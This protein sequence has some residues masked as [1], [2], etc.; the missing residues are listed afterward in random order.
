M[1]ASPTP[2]YIVEYDNDQFPGYV[3]EEEQPMG[4]RVV[5]QNILNRHGGIASPAGAEMMQISLNF[6]VLSQ[7]DNVSDLL[8][9]NNCKEQYIEAR[10]IVARASGMADLYISDMTKHVRAFPTG[11]TAPLVAGTSRSIHYKV[12]F[13]ADPFYIGDTAV[14]DSFTGND[15]LSL[16]FADDTLETYPI[17]VIP[18]GVTAF[19]A[20]HTASGKVLEF[21]RT[22]SGISGEVSANCGSFEVIKTDNLANAS[23]T[24]NNVDFGMRHNAGAG[25]MTITVTG[26]SGS[27]TVAVSAYPRFAM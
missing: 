25:T 14:T 1:P 19:T 24:M 21:L 10:K 15:T 12:T 26:Y 11:I 7:L 16:V 2:I 27:G 6:V 13:L 18:S 3:Q 5:Q 8:H 20:T 23:A 17:F 4:L 9:L 22:G